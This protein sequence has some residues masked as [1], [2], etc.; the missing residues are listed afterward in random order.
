MAAD[1]AKASAAQFTLIKVRMHVIQDFDT[2]LS[3]RQSLQQH[4]EAS[5]SGTPRPEV[6]M[7]AVERNLAF[8]SDV[9]G[10]DLRVWRPIFFLFF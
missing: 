10:S 5:I 4:S 7:A 8:A 9:R 3:L 1:I 2:R 6:M